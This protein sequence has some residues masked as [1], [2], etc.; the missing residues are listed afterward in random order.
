MYRKRYS[1]DAQR[2]ECRNEPDSMCAFKS[3][4]M[5]EVEIGLRG[6]NARIRLESGLP[7]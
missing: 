7:R 1:D 3:T 4:D 5:A 6:E 2:Q